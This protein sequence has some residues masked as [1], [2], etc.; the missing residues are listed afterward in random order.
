MQSVFRS[1]RMMPHRIKEALYRRDAG[2]SMRDIARPY[3]VSH[4]TISSSVSG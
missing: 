3:N 1:F 4:S 2:D